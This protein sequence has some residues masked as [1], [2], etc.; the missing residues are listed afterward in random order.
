MAIPDTTAVKLSKAAS[1][2]FLCFGCVFLLAA[3]GTFIGWVLAA[4]CLAISAALVVLATVLQRRAS[5][6]DAERLAKFLR[7]GQD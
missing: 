7:G 5:K 6:K 3:K 1:G 2:I 4:V